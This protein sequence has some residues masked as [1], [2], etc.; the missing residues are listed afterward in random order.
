VDAN[1]STSV[2][3]GVRSIPTILFFRKG[4]VVD[5]VVGAVPR[6]HLES[7]IKQHLA[8]GAGAERGAGPS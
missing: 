8:S 2:R 5:Q 4:Q 1:T 6:S 7:K 3:F